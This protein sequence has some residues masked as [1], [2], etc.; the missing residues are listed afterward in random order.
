MKKFGVIEI[1]STNTKAFVWDGKN[2]TSKGSKHI[3]FKDNYENGGKLNKNDV[4]TLFDFVRE[5]KKEVGEVFAYGTSIFRKISTR[6]STPAG[7]NLAGD[8]PSDTHDISY[9][10]KECDDFADKLRAEFGVAFK[11][12]SADD[13]ANYTVQGVIAGIKGL[14]D[15]SFSKRLAV[16]I[17]GGGSTEIALINGQKIDKRVNLDFGAMDI[18]KRFPELKD[19][20]VSTNFDT[21]LDY[22]RGLVGDLGASADV[23][24][25]AGG[26][27]I[28]F[29]E[30]VPFEMQKNHLYDDANQ[31]WLLDFET[32]NRYD[33]EILDKSLNEIKTRIPGNDGWWNGARGMRFCM[34]AVARELGVQWIVPTRINMILGIVDEIKSR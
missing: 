17:G 29:Y 18:T 9:V 4:S 13:E 15:G 30:N 10:T 34:N 8:A 14:G 25:L 27:Y 22:T 6:T 1:G 16:V 20:K 3:P 24:V 23:L 2:L 11:V 31:P 5:I 7:S 32:L 33:I 26:D 12:V 19:D 21:I 28:Y